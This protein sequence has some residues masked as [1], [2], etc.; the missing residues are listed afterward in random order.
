MYLPI[1]FLSIIS[2]VSMAMLVWACIEVGSNDAANLVNAVFGARIVDR[3]KA[4]LIAGLSVILG[5]VFSGPVMETIRNG[6]FDASSLN[7]EAIASVFITCY[8]V[9]TVLLYA[10]SGFGLPVSTT[11]TLVFAL[12]G[13]TLGVSQNTSAIN[14]QTI[15]EVI[16]AILTSI[17]ST[18]FSAFFFSKNLSGCYSEECPKTRACDAARSLDL[19]TDAGFIELVCFS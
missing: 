18:G 19:W 12:A 5:T 17:L 7:A 10:Y 2:F 1:E 16:C 14:W 15:A 11:A 6:V 4:T 13:A 8:I 3:K 9:N